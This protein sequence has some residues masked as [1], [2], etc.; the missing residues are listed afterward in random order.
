MSATLATRPQTR[1]LAAT[2]LAAI[3]AASL[4]TPAVAAVA[5]AG[6]VSLDVGGAP[7]PLS[8]FAVLTAVFSLLGLAL[9]AVLAR[10]ATAPRRTFV[11]TTVALTVLSLVPDALA[12]R[13]P[14]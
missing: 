8:G 2:G 12:G 4:A 9:A 13:L 10:R 7:I 11:R 5:H 1:S 14:R 3:A 6:G